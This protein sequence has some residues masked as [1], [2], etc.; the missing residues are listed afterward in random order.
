MELGLKWIESDDEMV[1]AC[2]WSTLANVTTITPDAQLDIDKFSALLDR[3]A[4][5]QSEERQRVRYTMNGFLI[6]VGCSVE[7]LKEKALNLGTDVGK[8]KVD[9]G[10]TACK[11]PVITD[12]IKKV[13]KMGRI[14]KKK[15]MAR[16]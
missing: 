15:K 13:E 5:V 1:C 2:G 4:A 10:G 11:V 9:M 14:G 16:C 8:V 7:A 12:Y 6:T 3:A